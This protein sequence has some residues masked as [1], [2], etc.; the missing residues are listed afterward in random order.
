MWESVQDSNLAGV[1][2]FASVADDDHNN[3]RDDEQYQSEVHVVDTA[4]DHRPIVHFTTA[5]LRVQE[6]QEHSDHSHRQ[7]DHQT[8]ESTLQH[9]NNIK[10]DKSNT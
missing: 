8:P 5:W 4:H 7:S 1:W 2:S 10:C 3:S 9:L 6:V